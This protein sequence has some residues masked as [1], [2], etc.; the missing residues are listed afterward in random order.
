MEEI[1]SA[2]AHFILHPRESGKQCIVAKRPL[3]LQIR[4]IVLGRILR[5]VAG[6][7]PV[8][9]RCS[10]STG[11]SILPSIAVAN[12]C[13]EPVLCILIAQF[14]NILLT[15]P[16]VAK[17]IIGRSTDIVSVWQKDSA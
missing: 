5:T 6:T 1:E 16:I 3:F 7:R 12:S 9:I 14:V 13:L 11:V 2:I 8:N 10:I 4:I 15:L 17:K